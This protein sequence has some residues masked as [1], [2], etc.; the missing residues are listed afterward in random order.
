MD[1]STHARTARDAEAAMRLCL[2]HLGKAR[3]PF[4]RDLVIR[5]ARDHYAVEV[6][7]YS[8]VGAAWTAWNHL[9]AW[10]VRTSARRA[11]STVADQ[12]L[13]GTLLRTAEDVTGTRGITSGLAYGLEAVPRPFPLPADRMLIDGQ[14]R[15]SAV[16]EVLTGMGKTEAFL[17]TALQLHDR[18]SQVGPYST[19]DLD[20]LVQD[21]EKLAES[22]RQFAQTSVSYSAWHIKFLVGVLPHASS[23]C[24]VLRLATPIVP[25]A[26]GQG[27]VT[28]PADL[29]LAA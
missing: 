26:P 12:D 1:R 11:L 28:V 15:V 2:S 21:A 13:T 9:S 14:H 25:G 8:A 22:L 24:G 17:R 3:A 19:A 29:A 27:L 6:K 20:A 18:M 23:P 4:Q 16:L 7:N 10:T 5:I